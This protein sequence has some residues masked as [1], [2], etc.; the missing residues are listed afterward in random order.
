MIEEQLK[1]L[2]KFKKGLEAVNVEFA[3]GVDPAKYGGDA[4]TYSIEQFRRRLSGESGDKISVLRLQ[5]S[6][7]E[8]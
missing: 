3:P 8:R 4:K 7:A 1:H 6:E 2:A 5:E